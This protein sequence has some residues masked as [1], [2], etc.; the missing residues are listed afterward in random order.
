MEPLDRLDPLLPRRDAVYE[1][2]IFHFLWTAVN[3]V[4]RGYKFSLVDSAIAINREFPRNNSFIN[5]F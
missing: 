2:E 4:V 1:S 3:F 5:I